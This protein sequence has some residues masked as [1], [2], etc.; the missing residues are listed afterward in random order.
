M[1]TCI[2]IPCYNEENRLP[3]D[4]F[5]TFVKDHEGVD[6]LFVN[7]GSRDGTKRLLSSLCRENDNRFFLVNLPQNAG[8]AE[9]VRRGCLEAFRRNCRYVGYWDADLATPLDAIADLTSILCE[10]PEIDIVMGA[11]VKLLGR[12]IIRYNMRHYFGRMFATLVSI[13][14]RLGVYDTQCGAKVFRSRRDIQELFGDPFLSRWIFDVE[15]IARYLKV[16]PNNSDSIYEYPLKQWVDIKG[17][18]IRPWDVV[19]V[20]YDLMKI[21]TNYGIGRKQK[22]RTLQAGDL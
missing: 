5:R 10:Q 1:S 18:K 2:I 15:L 21:F 7:D 20:G 13:I 17:S 22:I 14:L 16:H 12:K 19:R 6:F 11:R 3:V 8:K 9:A 4:K